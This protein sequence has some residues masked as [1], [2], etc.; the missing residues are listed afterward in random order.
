M[1]VERWCRGQR[2]M[3]PD[4]SDTVALRRRRAMRTLCRLL[5]AA[6]IALLLGNVLQVRRFEYLSFEEV[7]EDK[8]QF[9][10]PVTRSDL[11]LGPTIVTEYAVSRK[12]YELR[13]EVDERVAVPHASVELVGARKGMFLHPRL[14]GPD[15]E[16]RGAT[17]SGLACGTVASP[18]RL[19]AKGLPVG[20]TR[21]TF[22]WSRCDE[23]ASSQRLA[24]AFDVVGPEG[25]V[26]QERIPFEL[27]TRGFLVQRVWFGGGILQ[28]GKPIGESTQRVSG[29]GRGL[30]NALKLLLAPKVP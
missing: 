26:I 23:A 30:L 5:G 14:A 9:T 12:D 27:G 11:Y 1:S 3:E 25:L 7:A 24:M 29:G 10:A 4:N 18:Q 20:S 15:S 21:Y 19:D 13:I 2:N 17:R 28:W 8:V 22:V 16:L 6:A